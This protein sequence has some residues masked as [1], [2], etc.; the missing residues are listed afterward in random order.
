MTS[1]HEI[2]SSQPY[3]SLL[4]NYLIPSHT[5]PLR[6]VEFD[7]QLRTDLLIGYRTITSLHCT[8]KHFALSLPIGNEIAALR[9]FA[10]L[11][12]FCHFHMRQQNSHPCILFDRD[13]PLRHPPRHYFTDFTYRKLCA[14]GNYAAL[15]AP[16]HPFIRKY[17]VCYA[18]F[19][20]TSSLPSTFLHH[21]IPFDCSENPNLICQQC[22]RLGDSFVTAF[23][24]T[25]SHNAYVAA[26]QQN[27]TVWHQ[28]QRFK[29]LAHS[30]REAP[31]MY[32]W[33]H[34]HG[35]LYRQV[36]YMC[37]EHDY[38]ILAS[39]ENALKALQH[40]KPY[41]S[42]RIRY[43]NPPRCSLSALQETRIFNARLEEYLNHKE[44]EYGI[45]TSVPDYEAYMID[46]YYTLRDNT[47]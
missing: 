24:D 41:Q 14:I 39:V 29:S 43:R 10:I 19:A 26:L 20:F 32:S 34:I 7:T 1:F 13:S 5:K 46:Y 36:G 8:C 47:L 33:E 6:C 21:S 37:M 22:G 17:L 25:S 3:S 4:I 23:Y 9:P 2:F 31:N 27:P 30:H 45:D 42:R 18:C 40:K 35:I 12:L 16:M 15:V 11:A 44:T 38:N 28:Y